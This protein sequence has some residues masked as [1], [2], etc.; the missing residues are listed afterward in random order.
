MLIG[1]SHE[2][3]GAAVADLLVALP[4]TMEGALTPRSDPRARRHR[5]GYARR[6]VERGCLA[7]EGD[8]PVAVS[9]RLRRPDTAVVASGNSSTGISPLTACIAVPACCA[10]RLTALAAWSLLRYQ[11]AINHGP[12]RRPADADD[13]GPTYHAT[14]QPER[15]SRMGSGILAS[16]SSGAPVRSA[17]QCT[18]RHDSSETVPFAATLYVKRPIAY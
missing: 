16:R 6:L 2:A 14:V 1:F 5:K 9:R 8:S 4:A 18:T 11:S 13:G 12:H 10:R 17:A 15:W 7:G 3:V